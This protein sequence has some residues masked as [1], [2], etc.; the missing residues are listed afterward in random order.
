MHPQLR[1]V[2]T[3][4]LETDNIAENDSFE[5]ISTWDSVRHLAS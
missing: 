2:L 4:I 3:N 1:E 5:T